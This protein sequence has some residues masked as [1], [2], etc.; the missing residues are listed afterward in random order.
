MENR[1]L[2]NLIDTPGNVEFSSE[3]T[4]AIRITDGALVIV[5]CI[6]G[7]C[8]QTETVLRQSLKERVKPI[9]FINKLDRAL[10]EMQ[11]EPEELY[12]TFK[13]TIES[14]N[15]TIE[16]YA[17]EEVMQNIRVD[18]GTGSVSFGSGLDG[19]AFS[20]RQFANIYSSQFNI[21]THKLMAK[22][23][24]ENYFD[25][26]TMEWS[27][28]KTCSN[29]RTFAIYVLE[30]IYKVVNAIMNFKT[31]ET[32]KL[33]DT[34]GINLSLKGQEAKGKDLLKLVMRTWLPACDTVLSMITNHLP[35]PV[36]AQMYRAD[37]LY[38]G[39]AD[40]VCCTAIRNCDENGPLMMCVSKMVPTSDKGRFYAFG[41][42]FSGRVK[43]TQNVRILGRTHIYGT[44]SDI[45]ENSVQ[46]IVLL[47]GCHVESVDIVP[48]GN[49]CG[50][51]GID[52]HLVKAGTIATS[53][54]A[55]NF[56]AMKFS[57]PPVV[58]VAVEPCSPSDLPRLIEA[59][60]RLSKSDPIVQCY[61]EE[62]GELMIT[63][64]GE[65]H[66]DSCLKDLEVD[67]AGI[68]FHKSNPFVPYRETVV[69]ESSMICMSKTPNKSN[70]IYMTACPLPEGLLDDI[71]CGIVGSLA[72]LK[73]RA[74]T[75]TSTY[76]FEASKVNKIWTFGPEWTGANLLIDV[77]KGV[78]DL[79][80]VKASCIQGFQWATEE[81]I[82][83]EERMH[84]IQFNLHD[85]VL[86]SNLRRRGP[87]QIIAG[88]RRTMFAS[89][90][91]AEP[92]LKEPVYL[93][94]V[95]CPEAAIG[96]IY[97]VLERRRSVII[98]EILATGRKMH[99]IKAYLPVTESFGIS[100]DFQG[101]AR[102][103]AFLQCNFD[104]W[105]ELL[106]NPLQPGSQGANHP[107]NIVIETR[108]R[109]GMKPEIPNLSN[110]L[111]SS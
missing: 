84:G 42:V 35:S 7:V 87:G 69:Q 39:P 44:K 104:H 109:K 21:P 89:I 54:D 52:Q 79:H 53:Q 101:L 2:I 47:L 57:I 14:I 36:T 25:K 50:L 70:K 34:L 77:T 48:A 61:T 24:G 74:S 102:G 13:M 97:T 11:L 18:P 72:D 96:S 3:V 12:Q 46:G 40:D 98:E 49:I 106:G 105:Q 5:D 67:L 103:E 20:I 92:R 107:F 37:I 91:S 108:K 55:Y 58:R 22:L 16:T 66:I 17:E 64:T 81:G 75:L 28:V 94:E 10:L 73:I 27:S 9:L 100:N 71:E 78:Q 45:Y 19:W 6:S 88:T 38:T 65:L 4:T 60:E 99:V 43:S 80:L 26:E 85:I 90:L 59:I 23:W 110:Y 8:L 15:S 63:G 32:Q 86:H 83:C 33:L 93:C 56:K 95:Q 76:D 68:P 111:C 51:V 62:T 1:F 30:P 31:D 41:R 29:K 82:L